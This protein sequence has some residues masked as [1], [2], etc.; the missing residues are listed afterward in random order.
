MEERD[1]IRLRFMADS[2]GPLYP[3]LFSWYSV[4][5]ILWATRSFD[6]NALAVGGFLGLAD[7][8]AV[9]QTYGAYWDAVLRGIEAPPP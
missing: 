7:R 9:L 1:S 6:M 4:W 8:R 3:C 5:P 2:G